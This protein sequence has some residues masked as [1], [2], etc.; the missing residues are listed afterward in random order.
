MTNTMEGWTPK[1]S[2]LLRNTHTSKCSHDANGFHDGYGGYDVID[3]AFGGSFPSALLQELQSNGWIFDPMS[4]IGGKLRPARTKMDADV[5]NVLQSFATS[6]IAS[7]SGDG[8]DALLNGGQSGG[9]TRGD[10]SAFIPRNERMQDSFAKKHALLNR[11]VKSIESTAFEHLGKCGGDVCEEHSEALL[12]SEEY[13]EFDSSLT[14][15][16]IARYPGDGHAGYPRHCDRGAECMTES[17]QHEDQIILSQTPKRLLTFV[18]YLTPADWNPQLDGGAL[19]MF[20]PKTQQQN[21]DDGAGCNYF[22]VMPYPDRLVVFRSDIMEHQV[23]PSLRRDRIAITV[24][25]YGRHIVSKSENYP[26]LGMSS[27]ENTT[28]ANRGAGKDSMDSILPPPLPVSAE[29]QST[30]DDRTIFVAIPSY[31]DRETWPTIKSLVQTARNP[32]RVYIGVVFQVA[33]SSREEVH[34]FTTAEGS[35]V[36]LRSRDWSLD[37][38]FRSIIMD[39]KHATGEQ[40]IHIF[41][42]RTGACISLSDHLKL[43]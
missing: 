5:D 19:R 31:R 21:K 43:V 35:G 37:K 1:T 7:K 6:F 39:H 9:T 29:H 10:E 30:R 28:S 26:R 20:P 2:L 3:H 8:D 11:F 32:E 13:F 36:S 27:L 24:W 16:Q 14:S 15:V 40:Y 38:N 34:E 17:M 4:G 25:L 23:L 41:I 42:V 22:D 33:T 12:E 18:Y